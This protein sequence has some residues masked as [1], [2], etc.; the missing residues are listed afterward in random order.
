MK[1]TN[2]LPTYT[3][4]TM[5]KFAEI[6]INYKP[7]KPVASLEVAN[8]SRRCYLLLRSLWSDRIAYKEEFY[9]LILN[10]ACRVLGYSK[11]G[12]GG[13]SS[14]VVDIREIVQTLLLSNGSRVVLAHNHPSGSLR[15]SE[16]DIRLTEK[17]AACMKLFDFEVVDHI[18]MTQD[19][20]YSMSDDG[21][22]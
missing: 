15:P 10:S 14:V 8:N 4:K 19:G 1:N 16:A 2:Y 7:T 13:F 9:I 5:E 21:L 18:I 12:E 11:I 22:L 6:Q 17:I 3:V 20:F